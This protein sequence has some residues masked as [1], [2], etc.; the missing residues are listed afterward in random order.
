MRISGVKVGKVRKVEPNADTGL[1]DAVVEIDARYAP[2]SKD[3][4]AVLRQKTLL[5][6]TYVEIAPG[7]Q[8][9]G[10][11]S[12]V[13]DGGSLPRGQVADT[14]QLDEILRTFDPAT[15]ERFSTWLDQQGRSATGNGEAINDALGNLTPFAE[16]TDDVLEVLRA[17]SG[18]TSK[19]VRNT[20]EVFSALSERRGQLSG[21]IRN[22]NRVW[23]TTARRDAQ[24]AD[25]FRV[26]PDLP[27]RGPYDHDPPDR[28]RGGHEP[29]DRPAAP[30][31]ARA[32]AD[33]P[34]PRQALTR[35]ARPAAQL[36]PAGQVSKEG[37]PA[38]SEALD[39]TRPFLGRRR[40]L[41]AR[42]HADHRLP[43][44][45][46]AR[47]RRVLRQRLRRHAGQG[48]QPP[49]L[50][51]HA[52][53]G[54]PRDHGRLSQP[55]LHQPLQPVSGAGR[56]RR[57]GHSPQDLRELPVHVEPGAG[58]RRPPRPRCPRAS[59]TCSTTT[60]SAARRTGAPPRPATRR[61]RSARRPTAARACSR[62]CS[63]CLRAGGRLPKLTA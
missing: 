32:V 48:G 19:L 51:A 15:R 59:W 39:N 60:P 5:G 58:R 6:E 9:T 4:R 34:G 63:R 22:S 1:T 33:P 52:E 56:G 55:A 61:R 47:D 26:L 21:L 57:P 31:R 25:T 14:V 2:I 50:P 17:Q 35:P 42:V 7:S 37:L 24:L 38:T 29:A 43:R 8:A 54:Q 62:G 10:G 49:A 36:R 30:G 46:Q 18:A 11:A 23:E 3:A 41:P 16:N 13:P 27:A 40:H 12:T 45:L 53:P 44:P 28:V 20:G